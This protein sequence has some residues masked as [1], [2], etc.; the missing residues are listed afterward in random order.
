MPTS[1]YQIVTSRV[2]IASGTGPTTTTLTAPTGKKPIAGGWHVR[3]PDTDDAVNVFG[4][5]GS[6]PSGQNWV[7]EI[8]KTPNSTGWDVDFYLVCAEL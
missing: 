2:T 7:F 4:V 5:D 6:Y 3:D 1:T 8:H